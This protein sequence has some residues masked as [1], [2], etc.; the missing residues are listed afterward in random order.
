MASSSEDLHQILVLPQ[1][2]NDFS[3]RNVDNDD[4]GY[5][6]KTNTLPIHFR[7]KMEKLLHRVSLTSTNGRL[8]TINLSRR[9]LECC[10]AHAIR[11]AM[12][13]NPLL[14]VLKLSYNDLGDR[15]A[16]IISSGFVMPDQTKHP[17]ITVLDLGFNSIHDAG[18]IHIALH[19]L[20]RN[21]VL[22][23]LYLS[24]NYITESGAMGLGGAILQDCNLT[25]LYLDNNNGIEQVGI[26]ALARSIAEKEALVMRIGG[27]K[28]YRTINRLH[29]AGVNLRQE[30]F[31]IVSSMLL[32]NF[33]IRTLCL[34][35][36]GVDD[37]CMALLAQS[38]SRNKNCPLESI[39]LSFNEITDQG[40]E[41][42]MNAVWG[43]S[44]LK[45]IR[46]DNN[47]IRDRGA[48]LSAIVLTSV[49]LTVIDLSFNKITT[50]GIK[51]LMK[52]ISE[53]SSVQYLG[54]SGIAIE[55]N[56]SKAIS[57]GL[58]YNSTLQYLHL[59]SCEIGYAG[60]RH[61]IAGVVSNRMASLRVLNGFSIGAICA[62]LSLPKALEEFSNDQCLSF[63][64]LMWKKWRDESGVTKMPPDVQI[65]AVR[66]LGPAAPPDVMRASRMAYQVIGSGG[67]TALQTEE[68]K[69]DVSDTS[70]LVYANDIM[71]E[72]SMSGTLRL[73]PLALDQKETDLN[74]WKHEMTLSLFPAQ[75]SQLSP[76]IDTASKDRN[77]KWLREHNQS[78]RQ[79]GQLPFNEADLWQLHQYFFSPIVLCEEGKAMKLSGV[80]GTISESDSASTSV[81]SH[82]H[83]QGY[84]QP[85]SSEQSQ[86]NRN[87]S[88]QVLDDASNA[89]V[90]IGSV[91]TTT[92]LRRRRSLSTM[93][94]K[95][96]DDSS[97]SSDDESEPTTKRARNFRPRI[98]YYP[99]IRMLLESLGAKKSQSEILSLLRQM[100]FIEKVLFDGRNIYDTDGVHGTD[101]PKPADLEMII[102]DLL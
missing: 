39:Q 29:L 62:T 31:I 76:V 54:L 100:K 1:H 95:E 38:L 20:V 23:T 70:P 94:S 52:A 41:C 64:R 86:I 87:S 82:F 98:S 56:S 59:D 8:V 75:T 30:G 66:K 85:S 43:S 67:A 49:P 57:Y 61:I 97:T 92:H 17:G 10:D 93:E 45:E 88:F 68:H 4:N 96:T 5:T 71:L 19:A 34:S 22:S 48:Q 36:N 14:S 28:E 12:L 2:I 83:K 101:D 9:G 46:F 84:P 99:R 77:L 53:N 11:D 63:I 51:A 7:T 74:E 58:A 42:F 40:V 72:R 73:P 15:G 27:G 21:R 89:V 60:Q 24:G 81:T 79:V 44:T 33:S 3:E 50:I 47:L 25:S 16:A 26:Q 65:Q 55:P 6:K 80:N 102:I 13:H 90:S 91:M 35:K 18:C 69:K 32:T 37:N 78:L